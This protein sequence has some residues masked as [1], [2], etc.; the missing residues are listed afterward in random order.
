MGDMLSAHVL[1]RYLDTVRYN[2]RQSL[3]A[4]LTHGI[5]GWRASI[6]NMRIPGS[7]ACRFMITLL[8]A[9]VAVREPGCTEAGWNGI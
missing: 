1:N 6:A 8:Y 9:G 5:F 2:T 3:N 7:I 4:V